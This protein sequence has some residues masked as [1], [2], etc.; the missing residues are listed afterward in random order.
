MQPLF[1]SWKKFLSWEKIVSV[2]ATLALLLSLGPTSSSPALAGVRGAVG[3]GVG[4]G[5][6]SILLNDAIRRSQERRQA[7]E[8]E[9]FAARRNAAKRPSLRDAR[10]GSC[11]RARAA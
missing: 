3:V 7:A 4:I 9:K 1:L 5:V 2:G 8:P 11:P 6:A 10:Q